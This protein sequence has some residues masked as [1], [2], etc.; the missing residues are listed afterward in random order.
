MPGAVAYAAA[1]SKNAIANIGARSS[2]VFEI[3]FFIFVVLIGSL[4]AL[5]AALLLDTNLS[6][7]PAE[8]FRVVGQV[9]EIGG[10]EIKHAACR[11]LCRIG[12]VQNHVE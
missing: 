1:G 2:R 4:L 11:I 7:Q 10:V 8:V 5:I 12:G 6:H 9:V 3:A